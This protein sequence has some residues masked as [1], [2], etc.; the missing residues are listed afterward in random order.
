MNNLIASPNDFVAWHVHEINKQ[1]N[2]DG[3]FM[4]EFPVHTN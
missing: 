3:S 1:V 4:K 2:D